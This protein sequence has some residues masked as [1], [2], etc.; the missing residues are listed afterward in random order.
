MTKNT[1]KFGACWITEIDGGQ[2]EFRV[3]EHIAY[4]TWGARDSETGLPT[5][6]VDHGPTQADVDAVSAALDAA[7]SE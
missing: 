6:S 4:G 2:V 3:G 5:Y 7:F 1:F